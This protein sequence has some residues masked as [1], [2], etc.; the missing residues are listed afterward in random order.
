MY[1]GYAHCG[2]VYLMHSKERWLRKS[3]MIYYKLIKLLL[4]EYY[5]TVLTE[6]NL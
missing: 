3:E 6:C 4:I 5:N 1:K 2:H